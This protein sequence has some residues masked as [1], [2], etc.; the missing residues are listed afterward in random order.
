M[1]SGNAFSSNG[2]NTIQT[3]LGF[4]NVAVQVPGAIPNLQYGPQQLGTSTS[5]PQQVLQK[6]PL[7]RFVNAEIKVLGVSMFTMYLFEVH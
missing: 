1:A 4:P 6:G 7:E 2:T 5:A 3:F